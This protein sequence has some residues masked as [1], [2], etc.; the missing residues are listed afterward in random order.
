[1]SHK[2]QICCEKHKCNWRDELFHK[3]KYFVFYSKN[4]YLSKNVI[5]FFSSK[6]ICH[7]LFIYLDCIDLQILEFNTKSLSTMSIY[8]TIYKSS[9][10]FYVILTLIRRPVVI[11]FSVQFG[12]LLLRFSDF[13]QVRLELGTLEKNIKQLFEKYYVYRDARRYN[14]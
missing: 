5:F 11:S 1:V 6:C 13:V 3:E 2:K 4:V 9:I 12:R 8:I 10:R 14:K 7:V